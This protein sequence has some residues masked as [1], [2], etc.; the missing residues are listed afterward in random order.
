MTTNTFDFNNIS[1]GMMSE[2]DDI[3]FFSFM[4]T[5]YADAEK[6]KKNK[7]VKNLCDVYPFIGDK[8]NELCGVCMPKQWKELV[9]A[10]KA[11]CDELFGKAREAGS[12]HDQRRRKASGRRR[13]RRVA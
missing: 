12:R 5:F 9:K 2:M 8:V 1:A 4:K 6:N 13:L 7:S 10:D 3:S 11:K